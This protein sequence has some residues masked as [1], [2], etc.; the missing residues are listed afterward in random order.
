MTMLW[1][2]TGHPQFFCSIKVI[3]IMFHNHCLFHSRKCQS[4]LSYF[5]HLEYHHLN[6]RLFHFMTLN[7][8]WSLN[9][10]LTFFQCANTNIIIHVLFHLFICF[11]KTLNKHLFLITLSKRLYET[12]RVIYSWNSSILSHS[13]HKSLG[14]H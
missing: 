14:K 2:W 3:A 11:L 9:Y 7:L 8:Q 10:Y 4:Y 12:V 13:H 6:P 1:A 5:L